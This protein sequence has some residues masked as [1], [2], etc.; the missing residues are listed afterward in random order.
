MITGDCMQQRQKLELVKS[1]HEL[2]PYRQVL[3]VLGD[4]DLFVG[5]PRIALNNQSS[6]TAEE[7]GTI[8]VAGMI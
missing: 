7:D 2:T 5:V 8:Y 6:F 3:S 1:F 4:A